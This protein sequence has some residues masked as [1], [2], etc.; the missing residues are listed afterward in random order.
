[1]NK[2][3]NILIGGA[4]PYANSTLHIGHLAGLLPGDALA[5]YH[6]LKGD[7][8]MYVSG[9]DCHG[10][11]ITIRA[12]KEGVNPEL[13]SSKYHQ[14]FVDTFNLL[15]FSYNLYTLTSSDFHKNE[16]KELLKKVYDNGY[17]YEKEDDALYCE[18]CNKIVEDREIIYT[19]KKCGK[20]A[21]GE[22]CDC[23][24]IPAFDDLK[25]GTCAL[26]GQKLTI[27][28]DK[29]LYFKLSAFQPQLEDYLKEH[30]NHWRVNAVNETKKYLKM[31]LIDRAITR[32]LDW[33]VEVPF[34]G[35]AD[36]RIYVWFE[37]VLGY[38]SACKRYCLDNNLNFN[39][40]LKADSCNISYMIHGKDNITFHTV[41]FPAL[42]LAI[43]E[44]YKLPSE[45]VSSE[46]LTLNG[47]KISKSTGNYE[48][49]ADIVA[50]GHSDTLRFF[51]LGYGPEKKD[52]DFSMKLYAT[53]HN[54][55]IVNKLGN[56]V[57]RTLKFKGLT[58][59]KKDVMDEDVKNTLNSYYESI[60]NKIEEYEL[61][62]AC[63][64][65]LN[66]LEYANKYYDE[67]KPWVLAK[68]DL[69]KFNQVM[70]TCAN[71]IANLASILNP[72]MP[73]SSDK[74]KNILDLNELK[75][76]YVNLD[77]NIVIKEIEPLFVRIVA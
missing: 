66:L 13:I 70:Y 47:D 3:R 14:G 57:N 50:K 12:K 16:V 61:K 40:Y 26:C 62:E 67:N 38:I 20:L 36:K 37:A 56:F 29:N 46:Y 54:N 33:G 60:G 7:N 53:I 5:R 35:Y 48:E 2:K 31:G 49:T 64:L 24:E 34:E 1:M 51:I 30:E 17:I 69:T 52:S 41:I 39:D 8:V 55:E 74:I 43:N 27:K 44:N 9:S 68:E 65:V 76:E 59:I 21:K 73:V 18:H 15:N 71:I 22:A 42:L 6:R 58:E 32:N 19:C 10:T 75:W 11:P 77:K 45:I 28:K 4:W 23:G 63:H 25:E 72:F